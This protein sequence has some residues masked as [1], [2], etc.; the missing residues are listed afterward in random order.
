MSSSNIQKISQL[1]KT[2]HNCH[3]H[4]ACEVS[5]KESHEQPC[6]YVGLKNTNFKL[7]KSELLYASLAE[8]VPSTGIL[9][10]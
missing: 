5:F 1:G 10:L 3:K 8:D 9:L 2:G 4:F 7:N 6:E